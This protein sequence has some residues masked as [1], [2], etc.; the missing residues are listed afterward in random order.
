MLSA[1]QTSYPRVLAHGDSISVGG[2][3]FLCHIHPG[4][5]T[6][7]ECE[8]GIV[9]ANTSRTMQAKGNK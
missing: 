1:K 9:M 2:T 3:K 8:P 4:S 5:D 7:D 6:C